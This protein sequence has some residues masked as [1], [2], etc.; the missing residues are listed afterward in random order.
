VIHAPLSDQPGD[1]RHNDENNQR[2]Q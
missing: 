2:C 1:E